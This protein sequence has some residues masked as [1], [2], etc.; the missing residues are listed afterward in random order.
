MEKYKKYLLGLV[1]LLISL[2][3]LFFFGKFVIFSKIDVRSNYSE[4][5]NTIPAQKIFSPITDTNGNISDNG[6]TIKE[7]SEENPQIITFFFNNQFSF[8]RFSLYFYGNLHSV[9][10][11]MAKDFSVY[12]YD[13]DGDKIKIDEVRGNTEP[14]Y[15]FVSHKTL[16]TD[17]IEIV[18]TKAFQDNSV[19]IKELQFFEK[20]S[21]GF[22]EWLK[23][24]W[25][26]NKYGLGSYWLYYFIFL[27]ILFIPGY[28]LFSFVEKKKKTS[29]SL[30]SKI[31]FSPVISITIMIFSSFI[32]IISGMKIFLWLIMGVLLISLIYFL[33][34]RLCKDFLKEKK[35]L[36]AIL[37]PLFI[38]F[39]VIGRRDFYFNLPYLERYFSTLNYLPDDGYVG[40]FGDNLLPWRIGRVYF[41]RFPLDS[42]EAMKLLEGTAIFE[43]TPAIPLM[44]ANLMNI[45]GES[46]FV[47]QRFMETLAVLFYGA[48]YLIVK[49][50]FS[51]RV[52]LVSWSLLVLN[53]PLSF[54]AFSSEYFSKYLAVYP[55]VLSLFWVLTDRIS[56]KWRI[57]LLMGLA[58]VIH[59][60]TLVY[61]LALII[62]YLIKD[63]LTLGFIKNTIPLCSILLL[64]VAGWYFAPKV[65]GIDK[66]SQKKESFYF[67]EISNLKTD[68][69]SSKIINGVALFIPNI[70]LM[71]PSGGPLK[72]SP[73]SDLYRTE[74]LRYSIIANLTPLCFLTLLYFGIKKGKE[75]WE[76]L[77]FGI[78][79]LA[80][81]WLFYLHKYNYYF[82]Y[83]AAYFHYYILVVPLLLTWLTDKILRQNKMVRLLLLGSYIGFMAI[84]LYY[85]S[86]IFG[87]LK[88]VSNSVK[89]LFDLILVSYGLISLLV[90]K[91]CYENKSL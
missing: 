22:F 13:V 71:D 26:E 66:M 59:P 54:L 63:K 44:V 34:N 79:P 50:Y 16:E 43:R 1:G 42:G 67:Q 65:A 15:K 56:N 10:S 23:Y 18:F 90:L 70:L 60:H 72:I 68:L 51:P 24:F 6:A 37:V 30:D 82:H 3:W 74:I 35:L 41:N 75:K 88:A 69:I 89:M 55:V 73:F 49:K 91:I 76:I 39:L 81:Y 4:I 48:F 5:K 46:H 2:I 11:A 84:D 14:L 61:S 77:F 19:Q 80:F 9:I 31:I 64:L 78:T 20:K 27:M 8:D 29:L 52:A 62:F 36:A 12:Y 58:F 47:Y 53:V 21:V 38:F 86:G 7:V 85:L 33:R 45:F 17:K 87:G 25:Q 32:Y 83:G 57:G 40:Y 28:T